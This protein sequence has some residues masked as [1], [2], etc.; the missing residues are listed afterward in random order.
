[1]RPLIYAILGV[2]I[3]FNIFYA[4]YSVQ[5]G[6]IH[7]FNDVARDFLLFGEI[8]AKKI[9]LIGPRS[10]ASGLFHGPLWSYINYPAYLLWRKSRGCRVVLDHFGVVRAGDRFLHRKKT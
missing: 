6:E 9:M 3:V 10:N 4:S 5:S 8:D 1:M 2:L 7:F